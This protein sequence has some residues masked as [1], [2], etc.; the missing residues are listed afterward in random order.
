[1]NT[2]KENNNIG[3]RIQWCLKPEQ[4][5]LYDRYW[6]VDRIT[7]ENDTFYYTKLG[8]R[9]HKDTLKMAVVGHQ[10]GFGTD[11][12]DLWYEEYKIHHVKSQVVNTLADIGIVCSGYTEKFG[13]AEC[14]ELVKVLGAMGYKFDYEGVLT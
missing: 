6:K 7:S 5:K 3:K 1:M 11:K 14:G 2:N 10:G 13:D 9:F 8:K 12:Y 4:P